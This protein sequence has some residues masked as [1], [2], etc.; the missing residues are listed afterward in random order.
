MRCCCWAGVTRA[1]G[2]LLSSDSAKKATRRRRYYL[3]GL[4]QHPSPATRDVIPNYP[5]SMKWFLRAS[6]Q[7]SGQASAALGEM[8]DS[9]L[10]VAESGE[11]AAEWF[12]LA[13]KQGWDQ[14]ELALYCFVRVPGEQKLVCDSQGGPLN[15]PNDA[16]M[17]ALRTAGITGVLKP[18]GGGRRY[19]A[20]PKARA[21][22]VMDHPIGGPFTLK[23]PRRTSVIYIQAKTGWQMI[24]PNAPLLDRAIRL[25]P[26]E[27]AS[28]FT[29]A[30]VQDVDGSETGQGCAAWP[31]P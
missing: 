17:D 20:G 14:Q 3:G 19:H 15:C 26:Q 22:V 25:E 30:F 21:L 18:N 13:A 27:N 8:Y 29:T 2:S 16:E 5:E 28:Q 9:G 6:V 31:K 1:L 24:P 7:G 11:K 4:Y 12:D 23:Q 10:G